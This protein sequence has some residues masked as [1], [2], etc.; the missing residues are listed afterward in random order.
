MIIKRIGRIVF[1]GAV[2]AVGGASCVSPDSPLLKESGEGCNEFKAGAEVDANLNVDPTVRS[3][4]QAASDFAKIAGDVQTAVLTACANIATDLGANDSWSQL[5][6]KKMKISNADHTGACDI[7]GQRIEDIL[8]EAGTVN[9]HVA[10]SV[11]KGE[12]HCDFAAQAKCDADCSINA[13][14][15]PG[16]VETR[17]EPGSLSVVCEASCAAG[18]TCVGMP[19]RPANCM[20]QCESTCTGACK[21]TCVHADGHVTENDPSCMGKCASGCNGTCRGRCKMEQPAVCGTAVHCEAGC[22]GTFTDPVCTTQ[23]NPP[24]CELNTECHAACSARVAANATCDPPTVEIFA[25][26]ETTPALKPLV[27]TLKEN[28]PALF[29]A[30]DTQGK[31]ALDAAHR[32][33]KTGEAISAKIEDLNGKSLACLGTASTAVG[34]A[35]GQFDVSVQASVQVTV[36]C[37]DKMD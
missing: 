35:V 23:F 16:S 26:V 31:L 29:S 7:A 4:M 21:G 13:A 15:D 9:A 8:V 14:C 11:S 20:G 5:S 37:D 32:L 34:E 12:C 2:F 36:T 1:V 27:A 17:C 18:A 28:L 19:D 6:D 3:F 10:L 24:N 25:D 22:T 33:G 30:A